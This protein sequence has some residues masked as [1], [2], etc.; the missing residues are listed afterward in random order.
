M[1]HTAHTQRLIRI[2]RSLTVID[3][4]EVDISNPQ[5]PMCWE[6]LLL[7]S[8]FSNVNGHDLMNEK[9]IDKDSTVDKFSGQVRVR[10]ELIELEGAEPNKVPD[11]IFETDAAKLD[12]PV[13][14]RCGHIFGR[15][16]ITEWLTL[17]NSCPICRAKVLLVRVIFKERD[18]DLSF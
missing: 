2:D 12:I 4:Q 14:L 10:G 9:S 18:L 3:T 15:A 8:N 7:S 13:R 1:D 16:C 5:C 11:E 17:G 6:S